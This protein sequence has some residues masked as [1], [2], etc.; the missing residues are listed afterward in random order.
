MKRLILLLTLLLILPGIASAQNISTTT[1]PGA[2]C[3]DINTAGFGSTGIQISGT[4]SGTI[5]FQSSVD[6]TNFVTQQVVPSTS[7][8]P[9]TT[10]TGN[11]VF[12]VTVAGIT[13]V[14]VVFTSYSSGTAVVIQRTINQA[15]SLPGGSGGS[16]V[17]PAALTEAND[18]NVTLTL[19]GTP[20]TSLLQAT[21]ITAG[22]TGT[23]SVARGGTGAAVARVSNIQ[24]TSDPTGTT[25]TTAVMMGLA[26]TITPAVSGKVLLTLRGDITNSAAG[27]SDI[28]IQF[29]T[30][31]A[32]SNAAAQTGTQ[33]GSAQVYVT[34]AGNQRVPFSTTT[35]LSGLTLGTAYWLDLALLT[36]G[37]NTV[38]IK[39][40]NIIVAEQ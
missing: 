1:C 25:S 3:I 22:W 32:P 16:V 9:I 2:G 21:S 31:S 36:G 12:T 35:L 6:N 29:G 7:T 28:F 8:T 4:W 11:G 24:G 5:T 40:V 20:A 17:T 13:T 14:R 38:T 23:L 26:G 15:R 10:T 18:T 33:S 39:N 30:G 37:G 27:T 34:T 19:G